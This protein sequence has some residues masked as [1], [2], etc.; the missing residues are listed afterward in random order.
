MTTFLNYLRNVD[1]PTTLDLGIK[2]TGEVLD[3][4]ADSEENLSEQWRTMTSEKQEQKQ[5]TNYLH[6]YSL[7]GK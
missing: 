4:K 5:T 7:A 3:C 6:C 2:S 1:Q